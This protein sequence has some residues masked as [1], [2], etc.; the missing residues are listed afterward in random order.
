MRNEYSIMK[1]AGAKDLAK[2]IGTFDKLQHVIVT[3]VV[4]LA[5]GV[6]LAGI[7]RGML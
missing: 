3:T 5:I 1:E 7:C 2:E 6:I 4:P